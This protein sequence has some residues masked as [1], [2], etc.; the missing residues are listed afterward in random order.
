VREVSEASFD[1][2]GNKK[3]RRRYDEDEI[4]DEQEELRHRA[5]LNKEFKTFADK[6]ADAVSDH[7][8][9][10]SIPLKFLY[11][12]VKWSIR[13]G[14]SFPRAWFRWST[15]PLKCHF[16]A[17]YRLSGLPFGSSDACYNASRSGNR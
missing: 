1:E 13:C 2:T 7:V 6:V 16:A 5:R 11:L 12:A 15:I 8:S 17:I 10:P 14:H 9:W 4:E 3:R